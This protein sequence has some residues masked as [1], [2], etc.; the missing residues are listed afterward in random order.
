MKRLLIIPFLLVLVGCSPV[1]RQAY[2]TVVA[3]K[4]FLDAE[5]KAHPECSATD[6]TNVGALCDD[7]RKATAAK[8]VLIDALEVYCSGADFENGG[9]CQP[10][11]KGTPAQTQAVAK[12]KAA[13]AYYEQTETDL[14]G[15]L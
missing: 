14:K 3:A 10:P 6:V 5:K 11:T 7:L 2:R 13:L 4:A 15:V 12:L 1:E 8:D 9:A